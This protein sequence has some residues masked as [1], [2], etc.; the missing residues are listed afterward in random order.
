MSGASPKSPRHETFVLRQAPRVFIY[1]IASK[2]KKLKT[3]VYAIFV[4]FSKAFDSVCRQA[5]FLKLA[6]SNATGKFYSV[7][8][9]MYTHSV[10]RIKLSGHLSN[11]FNIEKGTEQGHPL[12]PDL[13]KLYLKDLSPDLDLKNCPQS[14]LGGYVDK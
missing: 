1:I 13:F 8:R 10:G 3:P 5:L 9:D 4:D 12:S 14:C 6:Q 2:Y 7:L 11:T